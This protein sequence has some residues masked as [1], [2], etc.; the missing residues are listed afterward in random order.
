METDLFALFPD[1]PWPRIAHPPPRVWPKSPQPR[2]YFQD[3]DRNHARAVALR[4]IYAIAVRE[5]R[6]LNARS[7]GARALDEIVEIARAV[8]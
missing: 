6:R 1:L 2:Q 5:R 4:Q 8:I 3:R 7:V